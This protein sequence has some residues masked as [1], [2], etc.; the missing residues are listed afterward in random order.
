MI[1]VYAGWLMKKDYSRD[2]LEISRFWYTVWSILVRYVAPVM[3]VIV[4]LNAMGVVAFVRS[5]MSA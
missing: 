4:F 1:A 5:I 2:E 3:V